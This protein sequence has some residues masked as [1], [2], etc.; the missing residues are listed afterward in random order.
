MLD[1][2]RPQLDLGV[3]FRRSAFS[4][5]QLYKLQPAIG[6]H[7]LASRMT[8]TQRHCQK[9]KFAAEDTVRPTYHQAPIAFIR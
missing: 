6:D 1:G 7:T 3:G 9:D 5:A 4:P 8:A 2:P